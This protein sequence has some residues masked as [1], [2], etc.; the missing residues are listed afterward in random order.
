MEECGVLEIK[1]VF[2]RYNNPKGNA[3]MERYF[4]TYK[5]EVV[6]PVEEMSYS[7]LV[8]GTKEHD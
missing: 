6:W 1:R 8:L 3:N 5:E 4:R 7:E 2:T